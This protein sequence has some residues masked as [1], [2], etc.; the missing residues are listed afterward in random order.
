MPSFVSNFPFQASLLATIEKHTLQKQFSKWYLICVAA[1]CHAM[2][3]LEQQYKP[4]G[5]DL[6]DTTGNKVTAGPLKS[7]QLITATLE[8]GKIDN[9]KL[10]Y[11]PISLDPLQHCL[12]CAETEKGLLNNGKCCFACNIL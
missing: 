11:E 6:V 3:N 5:C 4:G 7:S 10:N 8:F 12:V 1:Y 2:T 9:E